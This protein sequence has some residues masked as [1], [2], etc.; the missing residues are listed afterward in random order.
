[1]KKRSDFYR[2]GQKI[3]DSLLTIVDSVRPN[4]W[5]EILCRCECG[6]TV[7]LTY[8]QVYAG[9]YSCGCRR[10]IRQDF[11]D[12]TNIELTNPAGN[13]K[14]G[15]TLTILGFDTEKQQWQYACS[16]CAEVF[17]MYRGGEHGMERNLKDQA[18]RVCPNW[19]NPW[20]IDRDGNARIGSY[21]SHRGIFLESDP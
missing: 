12:Y 9:K 8:M 2:P 13:N 16:C 21:L 20:Y 10:R 19:R 1:M 14:Y 18:G 5:A 11:V 6:N 3:A 7:V 15:R 17:L 4:S